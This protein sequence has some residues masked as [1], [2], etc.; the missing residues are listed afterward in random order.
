MKKNVL[1]LVST[2]AMLAIFVG[3][4]NDSLEDSTINSSDIV[5]E[6]IGTEI[7]NEDVGKGQHIP[8][9]YIVVYN[10]DFGK[11]MNLQA[12]NTH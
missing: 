12:S 10:T 6:K 9:Q 4:S 11:T 8:G 5:L 1:F 3:C 7:M 2:F